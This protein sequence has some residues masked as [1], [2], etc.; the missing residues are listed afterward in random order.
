MRGCWNGLCILSECDGLHHVDSTGYTWRERQGDT[1]CVEHDL[2]DD[3]RDGLEPG[4][5]I[6]PEQ[7]L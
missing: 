7:L 2:Y 6:P 4:S 5:G 1:Y 3:C